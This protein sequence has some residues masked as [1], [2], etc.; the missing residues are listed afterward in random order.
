[1]ETDVEAK[2]VFL[3][4]VEGDFNTVEA[5]FIGDFEV[6]LSFFSF[7]LFLLDS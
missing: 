5:L 3:A 4:T 7:L 6:G 2:S 1:M